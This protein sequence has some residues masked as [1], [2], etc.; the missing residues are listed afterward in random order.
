MIIA[1]ITTAAMAWIIK[2]VI[3]DIFVNK[4]HD[5]VAVLAVSVLV[6]SLIKGMAT[7]AY[8]FIM[9]CLGQRVVT[10]MQVE[11]YEHFLHSDI[12]SFNDQS[13]G[14]IISRFTNDINLIRNN[15]TKVIIGTFSESLKLICL[16]GVMFYQNYELALIAFA[17]FPLAIY[18]IIRLGKR[19]RKVANKTQEELGIFT[20][21]LDDTFQGIRIVK[22][23]GNEEYETGK[24][25]GV[26]EGIYRLYVKAA[27][28]VAATSPIMEALAGVA[29]AAVIWYGGNQLISGATTPGEFLSFI[30]AFFMAYKPMKSL[31]GI[32]TALQEGLSAVKRFFSVID[33]E[34]NIADKPDAK[35]LALTNAEI[36]FK[37]VVFGYENSDK[38]ALNGISFDVPGG[39]RVALVGQSG[40][41]KSTIMNLILRFYDPDSGTVT[42]DGTDISTATLTS[43]REKISVVTQEATLFD[44]TV[45]AN[46]TYGKHDASED[47]VLEAAKAAAA[48]EFISELPDGYDTEIG[49]HGARLSGGQRQRI[50]I[51]R[52]MLRNSPI[53]LLDE[54]TSSLDT[55]S[56]QKVQDALDKL[57]KG[58]TTLVIAHR[59]STVTN[60]DLI[61]VVE[62]GTIIE[63]G[64]H[65][66]LLEKN[67]KYKKLYDKQFGD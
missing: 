29:A 46:I 22:A 47:E 63:S 33:T 9:A 10:N 32:N 27:R 65:R 14:R 15:L 13:T 66:E 54:A 52:A 21:K 48:H 6:I 17:A 59:L 38:S 35:E 3:D 18:P 61:Y 39:K 11:L 28:I 2:P 36:A 41:G 64:N 1:A 19:M 50:A 16:V 40:G 56:E 7:Y 12:A 30:T 53:L 43:L 42:I 26:I 25:S 4:N 5:L 60:S 37:D 57:M 58:R 24:A 49:Q 44:D 31:S 45:R 34:P 20:S 23:Y 8:T 55:I 51:A 62:N 67:G